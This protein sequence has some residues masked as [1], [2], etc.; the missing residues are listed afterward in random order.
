M[1]GVEILQRM[2]I[3]LLTTELSPG[4]IETQAVSDAQGEAEEARIVFPKMRDLVFSV[5]FRLY[6]NRPFALFQLALANR[7][8]EAIPVRRFFLQTLPDGL[9]PVGTPNGFYSNGWQSWS[10]AGLVPATKRARCPILPV[11]WLQGSITQNALTPWYR[12]PSRFWSETVGAV[13]TPREAL[14]AGAVSLADQFVQVKVDFQSNT[15]QLMLQSQ[16]D[17]ILLRPGE[18]CISEWFYLE[19]VALPNVD[20]LAQYAYATARQMK[21]SNLRRVPMGWSSWYAFGEDVSQDAVIDNLATAA[22]LADELP[23]EVIQLDE[24]YESMWGDWRERNESFP[25][26]LGWLAER[27]M[28]SGFSPGLWLAPFLVHARA[29]LAKDHPAWLLRN[30]GGRPVSAGLV[31]KRT[32]SPRFMGRALDVTHPGVQEYL[33]RLVEQVV[34]EWGYAYL[35][36]DFLYAAALPGQRYDSTVTRAQAYRQAIQ[37]IREIAGEETFLMGSGAPLGPSVGLMDAMRIGPDTAPEWYPHFGRSGGWHP[38]RRLLRGNRS[39]PSMRN[40]LRNVMTRAWTHGRWWIND[41]DALIVRDNDR[42]GAATSL[43]EAMI[44]AQA[45]LLGLSSGMCLISDNLSRLPPGRREIAAALLP[46]LI[47]GMDVLDLFSSEMPQAVVAP[48]SR[49]WG[50]WRLLG[51]F[52]WE[53]KPV[54]RTLPQDLPDMDDRQAYHLVDFWN[55]RYIRFDR[56]EGRLPRKAGPSFVLPAYGCVL[57]S[58]RPIKQ[59]PHLVT[60]TFH[61]SQGAEVT[62]WEASS[63]HVTLSLSIG[64]LAQG[65]V[66]LALPSRPT[67]V[68]WNDEKLSRSLIRAIVRGVWAIR[69]WLNRKGTLHIEY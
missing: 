17:E 37:M 60:T 16:M 43:T 21:V 66:W 22:L 1:L 58:L 50:H 56:A 40:S 4:E 67:A 36:L 47:E 20:P 53:A 44:I 30:T 62:A 24:G 49:P 59:G 32:H 3:T 14:V 12:K 28:G 39:L 25:H 41:P 34:H 33:Q 35:K 64:R 29:Q 2:P 57:L 9:R 5:R 63:S 10:P 18:T 31:F 26:S 8:R 42:L 6:Q 19:W 15:G 23:L 52:N 46:P 55:R 65:E 45:T 51:L 38:L 68:F 54:Q 13:V 69:F 61:I 11:R 7:G 27:I 48:V